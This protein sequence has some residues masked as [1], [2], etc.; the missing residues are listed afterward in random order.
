M[1]FEDAGYVWGPAVA[2]LHC[3]VIY[4]IYICTYIIYITYI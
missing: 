4:I 3:F 1:W 2:H